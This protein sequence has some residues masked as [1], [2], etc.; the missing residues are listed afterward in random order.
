MGR[1]LSCST[2]FKLHDVINYIL[3]AMELSQWLDNAS[4]ALQLVRQWSSGLHP[5]YTTKNR[6]QLL[7]PQ[8]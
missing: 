6:F 2:A 8:F 7:M 1:D 4:A 3:K 5:G